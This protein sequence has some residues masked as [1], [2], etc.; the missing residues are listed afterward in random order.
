MQHFLS[1][2]KFGR[3]IIGVVMVFIFIMM[4][5]GW[6][7][8]VEEDEEQENNW[9]S[10]NVLDTMIMAIGIYLVFLV[11][12]KSQLLPNIIF[13]TLTFTLYI[14]N[15]QRS[16]WVAR[17]KLDETTNMNLIR[18]EIGLFVLCIATLIIGFTDY[19]LHQ[20]KSYGNA[21]SW[22][23]FLVGTPKCSSI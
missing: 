9:S 17:K 3:H 16:Y 10:G 11:S 12:S 15:T 1:T 21:F 13:F 23:K 14:I 22:M 5:G 20:R 2:S 7:F 6:A 18:F 8:N 4:E 19:V